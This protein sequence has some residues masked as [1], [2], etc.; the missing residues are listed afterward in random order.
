VG[1]RVF[2][3]VLDNQRYLI[4]YVSF[5]ETTMS[6]NNL[7]IEHFSDLE[8]KARERFAKFEELRGFL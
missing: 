8:A 6:P 7:S 1:R 2:V 3:S 4:Y 5:K